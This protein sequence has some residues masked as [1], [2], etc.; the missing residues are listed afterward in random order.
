MSHWKFNPQFL[1]RVWYRCLA[2]EGFQDHEELVGGEC[3]LKE[4]ATHYRNRQDI[5]SFNGR[6]EYFLIMGQKLNEYEFDN[7]IDALIMTLHVDGRR[8]NQ[9]CEEL[10]KMGK[11]RSRV[12][13]RIKIRT[14]QMKWGLRHYPPN[15]MN[16]Y[17]KKQAIR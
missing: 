17:P 14:Y 10:R 5:S 16:I 11:Q 2:E 9:I 7:D 15:Q 6:E 4:S 12:T 3:L 8:I 1:Q 13:V